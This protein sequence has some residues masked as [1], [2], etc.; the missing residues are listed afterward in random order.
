MLI[1]IQKVI[2]LEVCNCMCVLYFIQSVYVGVLEMDVQSVVV[3]IV[4]IMNYV[5]IL[6]ESVLVVVRM[7]IQEWIVL[8]V[9]LYLN[10]L[11]FFNLVSIREL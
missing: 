7:D 2:I 3:D 5:I 1:V 8:K 10:F 9:K 11:V 6:V 4:Q